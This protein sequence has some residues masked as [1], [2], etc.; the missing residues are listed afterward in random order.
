MP[1]RICIFKENRKN[2][3]DVFGLR[4][5]RKWQKNYYSS[6][7]CGNCEAE[8]IEDVLSVKKWQNLELHIMTRILLDR[9]P[10]QSGL[11]RG[12]H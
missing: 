4:R 1:D 6:R 10:E 9:L 3:V 11:S 2:K 12:V 8:R 7:G 5:N